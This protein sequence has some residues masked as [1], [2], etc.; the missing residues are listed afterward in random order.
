VRTNPV[1]RRFTVCTRIL[2]AIGFIAPALVKIQGERFT[3]IS[4]DRPI[5]FFFE[6]MYRT[7]AYWSF[8]GWAQL[9]GA[10]LLLHPRTATLG[11]LVFFPII[12][13]IFA[14]T[15]SM[16]FTGTWVVT[17]LMLLACT[18]LLCWDYHRFKPLLWPPPAPEPA[19]ELSPRG[20]L[21]ERVAYTVLTVSGLCVVLATRGY[22]PWKWV[23]ACLAAGLAGGV[24]LL[25]AMVMEMRG[26]H[27]VARGPVA[28]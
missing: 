28:G 9:I 25:A 13:N 26:R 17:G 20:R 16:Q 5:G 14:I 4:I 21:L 24:C 10:L 15:L 27:T 6:A 1:L 11:A 2:L 7:G 3:Q 12:L 23:P 19:A 22:F 8:I 18:Y